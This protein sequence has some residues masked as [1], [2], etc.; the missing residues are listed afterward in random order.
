MNDFLGLVHTDICGPMLTQVRDRYSYFITFT[1][2]LS[3]FRYM[4]LL[5]Y[6]FKVFDKFNEYQ[7]IVEK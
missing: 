3:R 2:D 5:K 1:D 4:Y 6:K 7:R